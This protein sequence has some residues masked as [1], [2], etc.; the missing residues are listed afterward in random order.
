[1]QRA[2]SFE[3]TLMLG[4]IEGRR[5]RGWQRMR[6]LDGITD[7]V[8]MSLGKLPGV[9]D[10]Q[11]GLAC[12]GSWSHR[13]S[14]TTEW[15]NWTEYFYMVVLYFLYIIGKKESHKQLKKLIQGDSIWT[16]FIFQLRQSGSWVCT[17]NCYTILPCN[18]QE[19]F[20]RAK[21]CMEDISVSWTVTKHLHCVYFFQ[22]MWTMFNS[23][24]T[25]QSIGGETGIVLEKL[26]WH[27]LTCELLLIKNPGQYNWVS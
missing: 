20:C 15:L 18:M 7:S 16:E 24:K 4:N 21:G 19:C 2:D 8:D 5:R 22:D 26:F 23:V 12:G 27:H 17:S 1:M 6:W 11:G 9:G 25:R 10:G 14:D 3:K 13:E